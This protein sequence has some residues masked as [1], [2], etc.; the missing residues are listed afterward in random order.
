MF[1]VNKQVA[2]SLGAFTLA[3]SVGLVALAPS[4]NAAPVDYTSHCVN[5]IVPDLVIPD[6]N[7][8]ID[9]EVTPAK[10]R[11][12]VGEEV[13]VKW[14]WKSFPKAPPEIPV[15]GKVDKDST[16]P[17][18]KITVGGSGSGEIAVEGTR[19]NPETGPGGTLELTNMTGTV[20][21]DK[22]GDVTL[23]PGKYSTFTKAFGFDAETKCEPT[24]QVAPSVT[25]KVGAA[26]K[27]VL[28]APSGAVEPGAEVVLSG[29]KFAEGPAT[30]TLDG[31]AAGIA[32][33]TLGVAADGT[34]S[35]SVTLADDVANGTHTLAVADS[36]GNSA[37]A[38]VLV[39]K[40]VTP[41][42]PGDLTQDIDGSITAGALTITQAASGI[43][44]G[45]VGVSAQEQNMSGALNTVTVTDLRGG[46][47]GWTLTGSV[48]DFESDAGAT[49]PADNFT[50]KPKAAKADDNSKVTPV[51]GT[52]GVIGSGATLA[53]VTQGT[54]G[55]AGTFS[56]DA[57]ITLKVPA[58]QSAGDY[59][60]TLT[61]SIS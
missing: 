10:P 56:A 6:G 61:L 33:S 22:A 3:G 15:V 13:S 50:W 29:S 48:S 45:E 35:G 46:T 54:T 39:R 14:V 47:N 42:E 5:Q 9:V 27:P 26:D 16:L 12:D 58:Y 41:T 18:G 53:S 2:A 4:A 51:A 1:K 59:S 19:H 28:T 17:K 23:T 25:L 32:A 30:A 20:K 43:S 49:I 24:N 21:L 8:S 38:Q 31:D 34:L 57:D 7:L 40:A 36:A 60:A 11:Y 55:T 52:E 44:L 37:Q